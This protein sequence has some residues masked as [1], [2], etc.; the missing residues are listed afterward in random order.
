MYRINNDVKKRFRSGIT[1]NNSVVGDSIEIMLEK[2]RNGEGVDSIP[3][4]DLVYNDNPTARVNPI[5]NIRS[6]KMELMLEEKMGGYEW[7]HRTIQK[8]DEV[9]TE[10]G[11]E[12]EPDKE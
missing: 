5:T 4:R 6:D 12:P 11:G 3:E 10:E 9:K 2:I 7:D 1:K 8:I